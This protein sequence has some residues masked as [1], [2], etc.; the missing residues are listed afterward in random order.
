MWRVGPVL[1]RFSQERL[2]SC[3]LEREF[4]LRLILQ[5]SG[6]PT[7]IIHDRRDP[8]AP[9]SEAEEVSG[10]RADIQLF[11]TEDLGHSGSVSDRQ[12]IE[13]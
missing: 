7:L 1:S 11:V 12:T 13:K 10:A 2:S 5:D 4:D 6:V 9:F 3:E 8:V